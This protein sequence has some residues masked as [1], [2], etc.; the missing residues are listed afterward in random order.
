MDLNV[1]SAGTNRASRATD[2]LSRI[3]S[4]RRM[5]NSCL[6]LWLALAAFRLNEG[7]VAALVLLGLFLASVVGGLRLRNELVV[8][9]TSR[10][11]VAGAMFV[12]V[13]NLV[14]M[15][16]LSSRASKALREAGYKI[17]MFE[18]RGPHAA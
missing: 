3:A 8:T 5:V 1:E 4:G 12:P 7:P 13:L 14:A 9:G 15:G 2:S 6:L 11:L 10:V 17:G 16:V 18:A